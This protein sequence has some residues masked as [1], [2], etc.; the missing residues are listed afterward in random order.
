[1]LEPDY[2]RE[3][4]NKGWVRGGEGNVGGGGVMV[5]VAV[6]AIFKNM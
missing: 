5:T 3:K 6:F 1:M 2:T 4:R